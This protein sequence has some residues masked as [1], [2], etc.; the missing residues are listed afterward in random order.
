MPS[1][2]GRYKDVQ[3]YINAYDNKGNFIETLFTPSA[4]ENV[5]SDLGNLIWQFNDACSKPLT[6]RL[7]L[8]FTFILDFICIHPFSDGNGRVSRLLTT[9]LLLKFEYTMDEYYSLSYLIL[10]HQ[11]EYYQS[12]H[13]SDRGWH[14]NINDPYPFVRF[15]LLRLIEGYN[16][17]SYIMEIASLQGN[18]NDKVLKVIKD[19]KIPT[20]KAFIEEILFEYTRT[21]IEKSLAV[22]LEEKKISFTTKGQSA[23]YIAN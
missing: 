1:F 23:L 15:H 17:I 19:N 10:E 2:G 14:E 22:L 21:S 18:C 13:K 8:V 16:K 12:L 7:M 5:A 3:N 9:F 11:D 20:S 4:P 6:N